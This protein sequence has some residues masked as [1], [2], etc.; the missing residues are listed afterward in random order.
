M[1]LSLLILPSVVSNLLISLSTEFC[2]PATYFSFLAFP[3][4][5]FFIASL[6]LLKFSMYAHMLPTFSTRSFSIFIRVVLQCCLIIPTFGSTLI[7]FYWLFYL[8]TGSRIIVGIH[9]CH[10][11]ILN[12]TP[13]MQNIV[14]IKVNIPPK[15]RTLFFY[16][17][18]NVRIWVSIW[19]V[20]ELGLDSVIALVIFCVLEG[21]NFLS[22]RLLYLILRLPRVS[23]THT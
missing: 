5:S 19:S 2:R 16:Q 18:V 11:F 14:Q 22:S 9:V 21:S 7:L 20:F 12:A 8:L 23:A 15:W 3:S 17:A 4:I 1:P 6:S 13:C 10:N